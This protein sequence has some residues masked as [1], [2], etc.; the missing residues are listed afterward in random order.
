MARTVGVGHTSLSSL[1]GGGGVIRGCRHGI[2]RGH[3][4]SYDTCTL[5]HAV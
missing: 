5:G 3:V 4:I 1:G 2:R